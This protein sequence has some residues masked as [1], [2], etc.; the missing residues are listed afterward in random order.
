MWRFRCN[1]RGSFLNSLLRS[2][3]PGFHIVVSVVR[4]KIHRTNRIDSISYNKLYLSFLLYWAFVREVSI[5]LYLS[6]EF[7]SY[8]WHDR[9]DRYND[10]ETRLK[11]QQRKRQCKRHLKINIWELGTILWL[12]HA[13]SSHPLLL[14]ELAGNKWT[15]RSAVEV[16][17]RKWKIYCCV[18]NVKFG[19]FTLSFD[20]LRQRIVLKCVPHVQ[21]DFFPHSPN[22]MT[23]SLPTLSS[24][25]ARHL[26][27]LGPVSRKSRNFSGGKNLFVSAIGTRFVVWNFAVILSFLL[28]E[29]Y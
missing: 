13:S 17:K 16:K 24:L 2:L 22:E 27:G 4:K 26:L 25:I 10:M 1:S 19:I 15:G 18:F 11:Q 29:T 5:K 14:T 7:F 28:S 8:D 3:K 9:Y 20:R 21:H 12:L 23:F 6:Y